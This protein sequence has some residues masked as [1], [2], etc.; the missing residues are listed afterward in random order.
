[1]Q[2]DDYLERYVKHRNS[3]PFEGAYQVT[4][5]DKQAAELAANHSEAVL[6]TA[7]VMSG[8]VNRDKWK[9]SKGIKTKRGKRK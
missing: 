1:M 9:E 3:P 2:K 6:R 4:D 7:A 8:L 5:V